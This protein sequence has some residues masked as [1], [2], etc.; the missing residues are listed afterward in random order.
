[1]SS[2]YVTTAIPY[3]NAEPHLGFA[4]ELVQA[5]VL[6]RYHRL[7]GDDTWFLTGTDENSLTNVLAAEREGLPV[8]A[9]VDRNAE[10]FRSLTAT[11]HLS[12]DD[13]IRTATDPRHL[14]GAQRFWEACVRAGDVYR[15][16]YRGL[17]C[18]RCE[19]FYTTDELVEGRCPEHGIPPE[20][21]EEENYF[22]RLSRYA[23]RLVEL[24]DS[25]QLRVVPDFRHHEVRAF[26]ARGLED[27]SISRT[28]ARARGWGIPV[29]GDPD[30]V[31]Y[32]WFDALTNYVTA[33]GYGTGAERYQRSWI[34]TAHRVHVIGKDILRFHAVYWPAMLL[35]A[36]APLPTT[37]VVH[38]FLT[39][40]GRRMSKTLGTGVDPVALAE[41]WGVDA[42]RYWLLREVPPVDDA[43][44]TD[45]SF[46]R[47]YSADLANDLGN[48]LQR[49]VSM[50]QRYR[51]GV[52]AARIAAAP[53]SLRAVAEPLA[54]ALHRALGEEW[55]PRGALKAVW[56][57]VGAANRLVEDAKPWA[58]ARAEG[59]GDTG[60]GRR[61]DGV[62]WDLAESLRLVAEA[63]RPF[64]PAT[65]AAIGE[66]LGVDLASG[67]A[68]GL[69]WGGLRA[70]TRVRTPTPLFPRREPGQAASLARE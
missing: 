20:P 9:L 36:G 60:A 24:L 2:F 32:V 22:F 35:A 61:L 42:V 49:T 25:R 11:L 28:Q 38:G 58:L 15:R 23:P 67:W 50:I 5:D 44:Y 70:G 12:H 31:I 6:A 45:A 65:A 48:L 57:L 13:F 46:A 3:V 41:A 33:L 10:V 29:P 34:E 21:V 8:R 59:G 51:G 55:D 56:S 27:F 19:R 63:L 16:S 52:V 53:S 14:D 47:A 40:D 37:I 66:Q 68:R 18:V 26:I 54:A 69:G 7:C 30:Q 4:L 17:Y 64:L 43:D 1:M 39:R 62:L